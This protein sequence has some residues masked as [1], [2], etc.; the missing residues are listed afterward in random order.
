M[1]RWWKNC[2][3]GR[4][5]PATRAR[6]TTP[7]HAPNSDRF[8][9]TSADSNHFDHGRIYELVDCFVLRCLQIS[10]KSIVTK[11]LPDSDVCPP[12]RVRLLR[13]IN[14]PEPKPQLGVA[15]KLEIMDLDIVP[16]F[17]EED[18]DDVFPGWR[19]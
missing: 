14:R 12:A 16:A 10:P 15:I 11:R 6:R 1:E 13:F 2:R 19:V 17:I 5:G 4:K 8:G 7:P 9:I 3:M 18:L